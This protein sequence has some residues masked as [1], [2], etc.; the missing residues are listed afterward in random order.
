VPEY[1]KISRSKRLIG[2]MAFRIMQF[3]EILII[4]ASLFETRY[5]FIKMNYT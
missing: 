5:V 3:Q 1:I 4:T 2:A